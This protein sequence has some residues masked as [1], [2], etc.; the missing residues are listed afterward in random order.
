MSVL[1]RVQAEQ[2]VGGFRGELLEPGAAGYEEV[3]AVYN[4]MI[5]RRPALVA[6][7]RD[8]AD[9][10]AA[11]DFGRGQGI[12]VAVRGGGHSGAGLGSVE[13]G[14]VIDLRSMNGVLIDPER[15]LATVQAGAVLGDLDHAAAAFGLAIPAGIISTTGVAGLTLGGG[16]G[17]LSRKYGLTID[18]LVEAKVVLADGSFVRAS[19]DENEDLFWALRGGGGN[20]GVVT[21]FTFRLHPVSTVVGGPT[22]WPLEAAGDVMRWYREFLPSAPEDVYGFFAFLTVPPVPPFPERLHLQ[23]MCGVVWCYTGPVSQA[24]EVLSAAFEPAQPAMHAPH[25][26]PYPL[27]QHAF[28]A[29]YPPG[30]QWYWRGDFVKELPDEAID[31]HLMFAETLP[32]MQS[33]MHLYPIDGAVHD[34]GMNETAFSYRDANWSMV[35]AG[36]DPDPAKADLLRAWASEYWEAL[37]P[38]S[39]AGGYVNFLMDEGNGRV[40]ATYRDNY[41]RLTKIKTSY[42]PGNLFHLNQNIPPRT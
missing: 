15:R 22:L 25:E 8:V 31:R 40:R 41:D 27:L 35:M 30:E 36:I 18:N 2:L 26:L 20:F 4:A 19:E 21:S 23:K 29:L 24:E 12:E 34:V 7:C 11:L 9:V 6:V 38:F 39:E 37:H 3:R 32:T 13:D 17:Y 1:E 14:L 33:G 42:D 28:D 5:D 10:I 16:H